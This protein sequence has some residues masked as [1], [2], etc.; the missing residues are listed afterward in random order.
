MTRFMTIETFRE[1]VPMGRTALYRLI[2]NGKLTAVK[3]GRST[4]ISYAEA[5]RFRASADYKRLQARQGARG[6]A[7]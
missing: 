4:R 1:R 3:I 6:K 2:K 7:A 5:E